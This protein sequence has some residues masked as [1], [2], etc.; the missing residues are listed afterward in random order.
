MLFPE[1]EEDAIGG[2]K[3]RRLRDKY[4]KKGGRRLAFKLWKFILAEE[5]GWNKMWIELAFVKDQDGRVIIEDSRL[6][7]EQCV[8]AP[9]S[10]TTP[11]TV[12][13]ILRKTGM[14]I[15]EIV[16]K[17]IVKTNMPMVYYEE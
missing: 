17:G 6:E 1:D 5:I 10:I 4:E 11:D 12:A 8:D 16:L 9:P 13:F 3:R 14:T 7:E 15:H 2:L